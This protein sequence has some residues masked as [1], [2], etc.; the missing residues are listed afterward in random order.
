VNGEGA[1][2]QRI[3]LEIG[4]IDIASLSTRLRNPGSKGQRPRSNHWRLAA[5][6][7]LALVLVACVPPKG[8]ARALPNATPLRSSVRAGVYGPPPDLVDISATDE[9]LLRRQ[10]FAITCTADICTATG[11]L[12][13]V[14]PY[15]HTAGR[16]TVTM[17]DT[18]LGTVISACEDRVQNLNPGDE[19]AISCNL[20]RAA[21][22]GHDPTQL[23]V[24]YDVW[25]TEYDGSTAA[26]VREP[27]R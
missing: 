18:G 26:T 20:S 5:G 8:S 25:V 19:A 27:M 9:T 15:R 12:V 14:G 21:S 17:V 7:I 13:N 2:W 11:I 4:R 6:I 23:Q 24:Q 16:M 1:T 10:N 22:V 3:A